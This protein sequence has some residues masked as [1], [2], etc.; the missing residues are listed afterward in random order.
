MPGLTRSQLLVGA[1]AAVALPQ[2]RRTPAPVAALK[3]GEATA[4]QY[5]ATRWLAQLAVNI[6]DYVDEDD[7]ITPFQWNPTPDASLETGRQD[8]QMPPSA[9]WVFGTEAPSLLVNE[10]LCEL[11]NSPAD[12]PER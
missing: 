10:A 8:G 5:S 11:Q 3:A 12:R 7:I 4:Q 2:L 1:G 6:V 9:G